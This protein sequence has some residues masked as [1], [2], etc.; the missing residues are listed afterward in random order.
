MNASH[1]SITKIEHIGSLFSIKALDLSQNL[2]VK[3]YYT[4]TNLKKELEYM[5]YL[6]S[7]TFMGNP[8]AGEEDYKD[9]MIDYLP[10]SVRF[11]DG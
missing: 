3:D 9:K 7:V 8:M 4:Y 11:L 6:N 2:I 5:W 1:N 10:F